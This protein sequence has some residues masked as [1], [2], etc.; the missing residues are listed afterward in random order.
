MSKPAPP[1]P[2]GAT[3]APIP[4]VCSKYGLGRSTIYRLLERNEIASAKVGRRRLVNLASMDEYLR[5]CADEL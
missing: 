5:R 2:A 3:H 1:P 4:A